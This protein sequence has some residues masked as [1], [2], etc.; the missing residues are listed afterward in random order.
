[1]SIAG[2]VVIQHAIVHPV[3]IQARHAGF[4]QGYNNV[5]LT[6]LALLVIMFGRHGVLL[7]LSLFAPPLL[8]RT[9][10]VGSVLAAV[11][12]GSVCVSV[13]VGS[14]LVAA[15]VGSAP[16]NFITCSSMS[17]KSEVS[18]FCAKMQQRVK[19]STQQHLI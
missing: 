3:Y 9:V 13:S 12:V 1:M 7:C 19:W 8:V 2:I 15:S 18:V 14:V 6:F 11:S 5:W 16:S 17:K 10:S 4:Q